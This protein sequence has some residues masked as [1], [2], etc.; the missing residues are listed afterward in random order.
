MKL[1]INLY[2]FTMQHTQ[3][4]VSE[5][6]LRFSGV[7]LASWNKLL[8]HWKQNWGKFFS[9]ILFILS[10]LLF[11]FLFRSVWLDHM[12]ICCAQLYIVPHVYISP[13]IA[14]KIWNRFLSAHK[15]G[16]QLGNKKL[17]IL[18]VVIQKL[19]GIGEPVEKK[20][21]TY[22]TKQ[23]RADLVRQ[24]RKKMKWLLRN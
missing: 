2:Y 18:S 13:S 14:S 5:F 20:Q 7:C 23:N 16:P 9:N 11:L 4:V 3:K 21:K 24:Q 19:F 8:H 15:N 1:K 17:Q 6:K 10:K 22:R 12:N